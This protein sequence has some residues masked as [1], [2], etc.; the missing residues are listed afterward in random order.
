MSAA[1]PRHVGTTVLGVVALIGAAGC[2]PGTV[3]LDAQPAVGVTTSYRVEVEADAVTALAERLPRNTTTE[4]VFR[5][6]HDVLSADENGRRVQVKVAEIGG[7]AMTLVVS[8]DR[9]GQLAR[10]RTIEGLPAEALG[11]LGLSDIFPS[12]AAAPPPRSL[13]PGDRWRI[14]ETVSVAG[15]APSR[16]QGQGRLVRLGVVDG[17]RTATVETSY[18]LPVR[19]NEVD[20]GGRLRLDGTQ[21]TTAT[22]TYGLA[23]GVVQSAVARTTGRYRIALFPPI[24]TAGEP[25][26]G[27]LQVTITSSTRRER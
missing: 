19:R 11:D 4:T 17:L 1:N 23:D 8:L 13:A 12:A 18:R 15:T 10:V 3:R 16:L 2:R 7:S 14:D 22:V 27:T 21:R 9:A 5:T 6:R 24:G 20:T 26:P 25:V